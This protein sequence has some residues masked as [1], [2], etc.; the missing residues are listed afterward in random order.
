M[1]L[2]YRWGRPAAAPPAGSRGPAVGWRPRG[3][4]ARRAVGP[5]PSGPGRSGSA[6]PPESASPPPADRTAPPRLSGAVRCSASPR[7]AGQMKDSG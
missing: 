3:P 5:G 6:R 7:S 4:V 1:S 2:V